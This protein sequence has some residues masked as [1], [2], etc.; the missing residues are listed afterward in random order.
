VLTPADTA[1][2][3]DSTADLPDGPAQHP[4]W[5]MVPLDVH[6]DGRSYRDYVDLS[7]EDFYRLLEQAATPPTTSQPPAG[8]FDE[9]Y[10]EL[11]G[12]YERVVS[13]HISGELSGTVESARLAAAAYGERVT[14]I[15]TRG[16]AVFLGL[17][18]LGVQRLL[19]GG[20]TISEVE[21]WVARFGGHAGCVF[22]VE[23]LEHLRR[24]GRIGKAQAFV[25]GLLSV[26]PI[27]ALEDGEV[28]PL[29]RVRGSRKALA[30]L[31]EELVAR[32]PPDARVR[33]MVAHAAA[34]ER[35]EELAAAVRAARPDVVLERVTTIGAVLGTHAG[36][37]TIGV[38]FMPDP[39]PADRVRA[40]PH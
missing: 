29:R 9:V 31:V 37:G 28:R 11:L 8:R 12:R 27:L 33:A 40:E 6:I 13:L 30:A 4:N 5:R 10:G 14:V 18:V 32:T 17:A 25:G 38:A 2:V 24:G 39:L 21:D 34:A 22:S 7:A 1:I 23:T 35:G 36:P 15:D 16:V 3:Y 19:E 26:R 20:T